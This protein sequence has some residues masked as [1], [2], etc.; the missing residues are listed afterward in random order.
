[1]TSTKTDSNKR[2]KGAPRKAISNNSSLSL[3][4]HWTQGSLA[5]V[6]MPEKIESAVTERCREFLQS[7]RCFKYYDTFIVTWVYGLIRIFNIVERH[8]IGM[9][10]M[11][12]YSGN[13]NSADYSGSELPHGEVC[14]LYTLV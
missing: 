5:K 14:K 1:M 13:K 8:L 3:V 9:I 7:P 4:K 10:I 12:K 11:A 6:V 2:T